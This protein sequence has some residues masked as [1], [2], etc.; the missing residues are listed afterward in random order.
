MRFLFTF[1]IRPF[2]KKVNPLREVL[3][4]RCTFYDRI[5]YF[6]YKELYF[7]YKNGETP[8]D[9]AMAVLFPEKGEIIYFL[10]VLL[11]ADFVP[12]IVVIATYTDPNLRGIV[13]GKFRLIFSVRAD[14]HAYP[15]F[16]RSQSD[17][18]QC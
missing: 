13:L 12:K 16:L 9:S 15:D 2:D 7:L 10:Q 8:K 14:I 3:Q 11:P 18:L 4:F 5:V 6:I 1:S 17:I